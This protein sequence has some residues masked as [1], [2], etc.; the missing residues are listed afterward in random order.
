MSHIQFKNSS[1]GTL[2]SLVFIKIA[3][4]SLDFGRLVVSIFLLRLLCEVL[5]SKSRFLHLG[6]DL[7]GFLSFIY[8]LIPHVLTDIGDSIMCF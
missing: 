2:L 1:I 5:R 8:L 4:R 7:C 3:Y 6:G